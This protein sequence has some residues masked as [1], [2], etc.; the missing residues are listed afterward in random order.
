MDAV[1]VLLCDLGAVN[2]A[3][4]NVRAILETDSHHRFTFQHEVLGASEHLVIARRQAKFQSKFCPAIICLFCGAVPPPSVEATIKALRSA[5]A[6]RP[7]LVGAATSDPG[8]VAEL[9]CL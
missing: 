8:T 2:G 6:D 9:L 3:A 4:E 1:N 7:V 5:R